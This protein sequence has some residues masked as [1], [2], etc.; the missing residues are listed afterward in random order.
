[1]ALQL[2]RD[3]RL[4]VERYRLIGGRCTQCGG[5]AFPRRAV[6]QE[7][8]STA[9]EDYC[10]SGKGE[11]YSYSVVYKAPDGFQESVPYVVALIRLEEGPMITAQVTDV[12]PE[13]VFI[14][15]SVEVVLRRWRQRGDDGPIVYGYKFRPR[16]Q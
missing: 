3:W 10:F 5:L 11:V 7:C 15:M 16:L 6:C 9:V 14:G 13:E 4:R 8:G 1:M 12:D 2:P